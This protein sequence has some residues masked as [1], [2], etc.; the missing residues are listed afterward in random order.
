MSRKVAHALAVAGH[1]R[2]YFRYFTAPRTRCAR[3]VSIVSERDAA[4]RLQLLGCIYCTAFGCDASRDDFLSR[5]SLLPPPL[6]C[7]AER[8]VPIASKL[9][10]TRAHPALSLP[11]VATSE[12]S[13]IFG[14]FCL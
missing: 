5:I 10:S 8:C 13:S 1:I 3:M 12:C 2:L 4:T 6:L 14:W 9:Q 7:W 11:C